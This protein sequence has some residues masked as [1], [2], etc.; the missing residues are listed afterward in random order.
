MVVMGNI[1][2]YYVL[3]AK[4]WAWMLVA[5]III[6]G[7]ATY[8]ISTFLR[9]IYQASAYLIVNIGTSSNPS[10]TESLQAVPT[11]A[12]LITTPTVLGPVIKQHPGL[13]MQN[14]LSMISVKPQI[15]T[16]IIELDVQASNPRL[17]AD[18]ANQVSQSFAQYEDYETA[19]QGKVE[20]IPAQEPSLPAQPRPLEDAGTGAVVGLLLS[21]TLVALFEWMSNRATSVEQIQELLSTEI[22]TIVPRLPHYKHQSEAQQI[23]IEKY[24]MI[25]ASL[26]VAHASKPF[27]LLMF[28]SALAGE[29]KSTIASNVAMNLAQAGKQVLLIDL[30]IHRP[31]LAQLF[32][33]HNQFGLTNLLVRK[34]WR[35]QLEQYS[36]V[37]EIPGLQVITSGTQQMNSSELL[38]AL[39]ATQFFARLKLTGFDYILVDAPPLFAVAETRVLAA[40]VEAMVL[41]V[42]GSRTPC[43]VLE[44]TCQTLRRMQMT[45]TLGVVVNQSSWRDYADT[46]PYTLPQPRQASKPQLVIEEVTMELPAISTKFLPVSGVVSESRRTYL[47]DTEE[48]EQSRRE[49]PDYVIRPSLSLSGSTLPTNGLTRRVFQTDPLSAPTQSLQ[50]S[51]GGLAV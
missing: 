40:S 28:T 43:K 6:S 36:Q 7:S 47:P 27:K 49:T 25:C 34:S 18:L 8:L 42:N 30:N 13:S 39:T 17:A 38:Q 4:R 19:S 21:L 31:A 37:T 16:Q 50:N 10:V 26:N 9:P 29:G 11:F 35:L 41:V 3:L 24:H 45:R 46:H 2:R 15:N 20:I 48:D 14:L 32:H 5:G 51:Q 44:R 12:Q 23:T 33:L 22:L 1:F